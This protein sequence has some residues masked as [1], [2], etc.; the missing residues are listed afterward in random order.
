M[1]DP[2]YIDEHLAALEMERSGIPR[3]RQPPMS[4]KYRQMTAA[5]VGIDDL[6]SMIDAMPGVPVPE[7]YRRTLESKA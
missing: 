7:V 2:I 6:R 4:G 3:D 5:G 1:P